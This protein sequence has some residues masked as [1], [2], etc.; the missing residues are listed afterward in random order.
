MTSVWAAVL[1][2][3]KRAAR[4]GRMELRHLR[5]FIAVAEAGS[6]SDAARRL[7]IAQPPLSQQIAALEQELEARLFHRTSRGVSLTP[8]GEAFL[9]EAHLTLAQSQKA[10]QSAR[11]AERG[12]TGHLEIG[13]ITS[14]TNAVVSRAIHRFRAAHP[15]VTLALHDLCEA[16]IVRRVRAGSLDA[17]FMRHAPEDDTLEAVEIWRD[18]LVVALADDHPLANR[19]KSL[20]LDD[21]S[22]EAFIMLSPERYPRAN[23]CIHAL[24]STH[25][26]TAQV[27][28]HAGDYQSLLW[29]VSTGTGITIAADSLRCCQREGLAWRPLRDDAT[30]SPLLMIHRRSSVPPALAHFQ[31]VLLAEAKTHS[32]KRRSHVE[33]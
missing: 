19:R 22:G 3:G 5:Y 24:C 25:G 16:E 17:G 4:L 28:Q 18:T 7:R 32:K 11:R 21:L 12:E 33:G 6:F 2:A 23:H 29:L 30:T 14:A 1:P 31:Q 26:F 9:R 15:Q 8:A 10:V 20:R 27:A 13:F